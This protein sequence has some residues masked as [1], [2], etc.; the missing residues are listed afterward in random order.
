MH[1][2]G[3]SDA[4][5]ERYNPLQQHRLEQQ[6]PPCTRLAQLVCVPLVTNAVPREVFV[7]WALSC[8]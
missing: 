1:V 4:I 5:W 7:L 8:T 6:I 2:P 3:D